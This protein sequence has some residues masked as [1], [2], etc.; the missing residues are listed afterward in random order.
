MSLNR[1]F[2]GRLIIITAVLCYVF[3]LATQ[4][5]DALA[6]TKPHTVVA[7]C[8]DG[9][10]TTAIATGGNITFNCPSP[11]TINIT[12]QKTI[13]TNISIDGSNN[14]HQMILDGGNNVRLLYVSGSGNL[15]LSNIKITHGVGD[16]ASPDAGFGGGIDNAGTLS[17]NSVTLEN[18]GAAHGGGLYNADTGTANL[19]QTSFNSN[20]SSYGGGGLFN[21]GVVLNVNSSGFTNN[22]TNN[23]GAAIFDNGGASNFNYVTFDSNNA[24]VTGGSFFINSGIVTVTNSTFNNNQAEGFGGAIY[25]FNSVTNAVLTLDKDTFTNNKVTGYN[26]SFQYDPS[27]GAIYMTGGNS[28]NISNSAFTSN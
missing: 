18:N 5:T 8:T 17:L 4:S 1:H 24:I 16:S 2:A 23:Y 26:S 15:T 9:G 7:D 20:S 28:L 21:N 27:G 12:S 22:T 13:A 6:A 14:G 11:C 10:L 3:I 19:N 25:D